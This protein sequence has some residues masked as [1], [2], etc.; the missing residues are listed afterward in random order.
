MVHSLSQHLMTVHKFSAL[1][2]EDMALENL[3]SN[4]LPVE[5]DSRSLLFLLTCVFLVFLVKLTGYLSSQHGQGVMAA[6][7]PPAFPP[8]G[9]SRRLFSAVSLFM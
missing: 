9:G 3:C 6:L 8:H 4:L 1:R 7:S 5:V 2:I